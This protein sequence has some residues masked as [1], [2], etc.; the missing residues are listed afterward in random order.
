M[1]KDTPTPA[2]TG[3]TPPPVKTLQRLMTLSSAY[4]SPRLFGADNVDP[5]RPALFVGNHGLYGLIDSPLF[6]LELYRRTGVYPRALGDHFHFDIPVWGRTLLRWGAVEG[7]PENCRALMHDGQHVLVFPGGAREVAM[8]RDE[9]HQLVWKQRTGFARLAIEHG[10]DIIPFASAGCDRSFRILYDGNDFR[11]SRLGK[12][13]LK[14]P[15]LNKLLRDGD[16]FM[17]LARGVGPTLIPRPEPFWFEIGKPIATGPVQGRQDEKAVCWQIRE[18][19]ADSINGMLAS[20]EERRQQARQ[21]GWRRW[22]LDQ[23]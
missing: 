7:T 3:F 6:M 18:Q 22:L 4:F 9:V 21:K 11:Q 20:L 14:R 10:Y 16:L 5:Q 15:G 17:P 19:V 23:N 13:L 1:S 2:I 8:R 12:R